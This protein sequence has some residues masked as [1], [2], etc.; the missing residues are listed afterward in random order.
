MVNRLIIKIV[1]QKTISEF[2]QTYFLSQSPKEYFTKVATKIG[3][4]ICLGKFDLFGINNS[5]EVVTMVETIVA[6]YLFILY[7][8]TIL[9]D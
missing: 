7:Y 8:Y 1:I 3:T 5:K 6:K 4:I 9:Y 2:V